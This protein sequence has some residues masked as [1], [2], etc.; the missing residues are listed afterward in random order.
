[1]SSR[2][3]LFVSSGFGVDLNPAWDFMQDKPKLQDTH[4]T[5]TGKE[6]IYLWGSY[7]YFSF[8]LMHVDSSTAAQV[9]SWWDSNA[10]LLFT[11]D[12]GATVHSVHLSNADRPLSNFSQPDDT[13]FD[14]T[15]ELSTY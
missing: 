9:N 14:G 10:D 6:L 4:R 11:T 13:M 8:S 12:S 2:F 7:E 5:R 1:M 15:I 3:M